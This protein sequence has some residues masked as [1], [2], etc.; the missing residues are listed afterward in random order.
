ITVPLV[1]MAD[2]WFIAICVAGLA[3][4]W[5]MRVPLGRVSRAIVAATVVLL[6]AKGALLAR[7]ARSSPVPVT[8]Q[9]IDPHW[10]SLTDWS[11]F[12]RTSDEVRAW[13][14]SGLGG[15]ARASPSPPPPARTDALPAA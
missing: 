13:T 1:A 4:R 2:P 15:P 9:A 8:L 10:G 6:A 14:I 3:A 7:A 12:A 5:P 11:I